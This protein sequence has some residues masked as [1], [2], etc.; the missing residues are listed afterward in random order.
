MQHRQ[1]PLC[2]ARKQ[3]MSEFPASFSA[4]V[5]KTAGS[6]SQPS[7]VS[8][9]C[10]SKEP[11]R[12]DAVC[13]HT[14]ENLPIYAQER[15][16]WLMVNKSVNR[17]EAQSIVISE[18]PASFPSPHS[19]SPQPPLLTDDFKF[20]AGLGI[21][22]GLIGPYLQPHLALLQHL[23]LRGINRLKT[24]SIDT[25]W[26]DAV[27]SVYSNSSTKVTVTV[28]IPNCDLQTAA[29]SR[30]FRQAAVKTLT[31]Y[32]DIIGTLAIGNEPDLKENFHACW[33]QVGAA[34]VSMDDEVH[35]AGLS[36]DVTV[37]FCEAVMCSTW[38]VSESKF[39][40]DCVETVKTIAARLSLRKAPFSINLYPFFSHMYNSA[41]IPISV[42]TGG[43]FLQ[44]LLDCVG[45]CL[46]KI[47]FG[48][49]GVVIGET[50][51]PTS[52][53]PAATPVNA[54]AFLE[55]TLK[56]VTVLSN[57]KTSKLGTVYLFEAFDEASKPGGDHE[58]HF[59]IF[60]QDGKF[61]Y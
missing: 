56:L 10:D 1:L 31:Q 45:V 53:H 9:V 25:H 11:Y 29:S 55:S 14:A 49:L 27:R 5:E 23:K 21:G 13:G 15:V 24:W 38:P 17:A 58:R 54:R 28:A 18:F 59:G 6:T 34:F 20:P 42:A 30:E 35:S 22:Y 36:I 16:Q 61:K 47:G 39:R 19:S 40:P 7:G 43:A 3:V 33:H 50:G 12:A 51:W 8:A 44:Q 60:K 32:T 52:G 46:A 4:K 48:N 37:P 26:L 2:A 57:C 41:D